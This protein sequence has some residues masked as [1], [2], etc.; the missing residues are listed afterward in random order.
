MAP[1]PPGSSSIRVCLADDAE[2]MVTELGETTFQYLGGEPVTRAPLDVHSHPELC[3]VLE[4][5]LVVQTRTRSRTLGAGSVLLVPPGVCH[6]PRSAAGRTVMLWL[7]GA[8]E[9][10]TGAITSMGTDGR[11][12]ALE[13]FDLVGFRRAHQ[14]MGEMVRECQRADDGWLSV[15]RNLAHNLVIETRRALADAAGSRETQVYAPRLRRIAVRA[16]RFLEANY[17]RG[18]SVADV[19]QAVGLSQN[20]LATVFRREQGVTINDYLTELRLEEARC[21]LAGTDKSVAEI[22]WEIGYASPFYFS[23]LFARK[24]GR[25]P[26]ESRRSQGARLR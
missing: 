22:S 19:A 8:V 2:R 16:R 11:W 7:V 3:L 6:K 5:E 17:R 24:V 1:L 25:T 10:A 9:V 14:L 18:L 21:L 12:T 23:R 13:S 26:T 20:Y 15:V 4:G